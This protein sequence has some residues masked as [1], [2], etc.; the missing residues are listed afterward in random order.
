M[1]VRELTQ[2]GKLVDSVADDLA[3]IT[4]TA[5]NI[6]IENPTLSQMNRRDLENIVSQCAKIQAKIKEIGDRHG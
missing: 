2:I 1:A 4:M 6:K 3:V 5:I